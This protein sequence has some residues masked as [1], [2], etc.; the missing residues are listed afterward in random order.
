MDAKQIMKF[1]EDTAYIH[2][3]GTEQEKQVAAYISDCCESV[4]L[5]TTTEDFDVPMA[6][7]HNAK[8]YAG[9]EEIPC[10]AYRCS[11]NADVEAPLFY[12]NTRGDA[13]AQ[14]QCKGKI[15]LLETGVGYWTYHDLVESG[16]VGFIT[17]NGDVRVE[18]SDIDDRELRTY[19]SR[20]LK[21]IPGVNIHARSAVKMIADGVQTARIVLNQDQYTGT[22]QNVILDLPGDID[23]TIVFTAHYDSTPLSKGTYDNMSGSAALLSLARYY[24]DHP[25]RHSLRFVWCGSEERG[26]L[27]SKSYVA[28]HAEE[29]KDVVLNINIDMIGSI[30]GGFRAVSTAEEGLA[31]FI[32]YLSMI[33]GVCIESRQDIYSSDSTPFA[34]AGVPAISF[35][36]IAPTNTA[37]AHNRYDTPAVMSGPQMVY[38]IDFIRLF[39]DQMANAVICPVKREIPDKMKEKL[40]TYLSRKRSKP[41]TF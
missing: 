1:L 31:Y 38:D 15:V 9:G 29:L 25:H 22:S 10:M 24:K 26:L 32:R 14:S 30:M 4:G 20:D 36:R 28:T 33:H 39:A 17:F 3:G 12:L 2:V 16:A 37:T 35:A 27:G 21:I 34:D 40:D 8:L 5:H 23:K 11:G 19:V 41:F 18:D 7:V 6:T 13:Y